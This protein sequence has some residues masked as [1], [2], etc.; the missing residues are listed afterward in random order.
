MGKIR[1]LVVDDHP[2]FRS[3]LAQWLNQQERVICC[4]EAGSV[5]EARR[6]VAELQPDVVLMDLR[7]GDG[8]GLELI[9]ELAPQQPQLR[10]VRDDEH[11]PVGDLH[12]EPHDREL[13]G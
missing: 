4:G 3:G 7:L 6:A 11:V 10:I 8:E 12:A 2:F 13:H 9:R 5:V 1:V